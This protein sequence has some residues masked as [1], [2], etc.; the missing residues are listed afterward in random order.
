VAGSH[1]GIYE[2][3]Y[4]QVGVVMGADILQVVKIAVWK[5]IAIYIT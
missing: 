1:N 2:A 3:Y 4:Q 5:N